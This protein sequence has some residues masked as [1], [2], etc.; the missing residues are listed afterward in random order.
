M[1]C[2]RV[3]LNY[4]KQERFLNKSSA[5]KTRIAAAK[6]IVPVL[7][8]KGSFSGKAPGEF[9]SRDQ[10]FIKQLSYGTLRYLPKL[11]CMLNQ[12]LNKPLKNIEIKALILIALYQLFYLKTPPHA[13]ISTSVDACKKL[14]QG[15]ATG[16]VNAVLRNAIRTPPDDKLSNKAEFKYIHAKWMVESFQKH[17]H[18]YF[19]QIIEANNNQPQLTLRCVN[20]K[21]SS[22]LFDKENIEYQ[23]S[24]TFD[25][26]LTLT[27]AKSVTE[28]PGFNE[29]VVSVQDTSAQW[30][31]KLL[32]LKPNQQV[33]DACAAPGGKTAHCLQLESI[34]LTAVDISAKRLNQVKENLQRIGAR[35]ENYRLLVTDLLNITDQQFDRILLDAPCS[36]TGVIRRHPDIKTLRRPS[37]IIQF[38]RQQEKLLKHCWSLLKTGGILLYCTCSIMPEE[39]NQLIKR[40]IEQFPNCKELP[41]DSRCGIA[42]NFGRQILPSAKEGDGFYYA[43]LIKT[44]DN[45]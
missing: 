33:L 14:N 4:L 18:Q 43:R 2:F 27:K 21:Q 24:E 17:W 38:V 1:T 32:D 36:G 16:L 41:I 22:E 42:Q 31:A 35:T 12:L 34:N 11:G 44:T 26:A 5:I 8:D 10:S 7:A 6:L 28:I 37:D 29:G 3:M 23:L 9:S 39:N 13:A 40:F 20:R 45:S 30:A 19:E 25:S 15:W